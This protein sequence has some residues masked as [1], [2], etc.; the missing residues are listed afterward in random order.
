MRTLIAVLLLLALVKTVAFAQ[1][2]SAPPP[3]LGILM[4]A[5]AKTDDPATQLNFLRGINAALKGRRGVTAPAEWEAISKKLTESENAEVREQAQTLAAVFGSASAFEEMRRVL[6]DSHAER[7]TREKALESLVAGKDRETLPVLLR[8]TK[9]SGPL[10]RAALRALAAF[11][12]ET[13]PAVILGAYP[14]LDTEEKRDAI[15][16]L[17]ARSS[18]ARALV[19]ALDTRHIPAADLAAAQVRQLKSLKDP[20]VDEWLKRN[21]SLTLGSADKQAEI[22]RY[23]TFLTP[24]RIKAGDVNRGR[25]FYAQACAACH[26]LFDAG[27]QIGPELTGANRTDADYLL[28]NILDPNAFIGADYQNTTIQTKDGRILAGMIR[29]EDASAVTIK[30]LADQVIVPRGDIKSIAVS[31]V[32]MMPEGLLAALKPDDV[33]D[34]FAYL[35]SP[36]QAPLLVIPINA[37]D[38][39]NGSDLSRWRTASE[40][41]RV[42]NG[43][44]IGKGAGGAAKALISEM[45]AD[46]FKLTARLRLSGE[47]ATAEIAFRGTPGETPFKGCSLSLGGKAPVNVWKYSGASPVNIGGSVALEPGTWT[48][49]EISVSGDRVRISLGGQVAVEFQDSLVAGRGGFAF[50][51]SGQG[52]EFAVKDLRIEVPSH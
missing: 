39:F 30:T 26:V 16:T 40:A 31:E 35:A 27:G 11:E 37:A 8:L 10:R 21:A 51:V 23:K 33:R 1:D 7:A 19:A 43:V 6:A 22:A 17:L 9:E 44:L 2:D 32:S 34:L 38:F 42:E 45:V 18:W 47:D 46:D 24:D 14:N 28:Q 12:E 3:A 48:P 29:G 5:L 13:I 41:W 36:G 52:A 15:G 50:Y 4:Q 20:Q 49:C 25:A